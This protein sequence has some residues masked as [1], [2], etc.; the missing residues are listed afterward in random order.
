MMPEKL[1]TPRTDRNVEKYLTTATVANLLQVTPPTVANWVDRGQLAAARTAGGHRRIA[2]PDLVDFCRR[3]KFSVPK[4][5]WH[6]KI[7]VLVVDDQPEVASWISEEISSL[8]P[9]IET[10]V[11]HDGFGAG[12]LVASWGPNVVTLD[13]RMPGID[14]YEVCRRIKAKTK[15]TAVI[16]ITAHYS[17]DV[18]KR[19]LDCGA[20]ACLAKPVDSDELHRELQIALGG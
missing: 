8:D 7:R 1:L 4:E 14:G 17:P 11:A 16:A 5:L 18:A 13:L 20:Q 12:D 9:N 2:I 19:I 3:Q 10:R 15:D 6:A